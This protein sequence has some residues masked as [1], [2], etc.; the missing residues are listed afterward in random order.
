MA[1]SAWNTRPLSAGTPCSRLLGADRDYRPSNSGYIL[2]PFSRELNQLVYSQDSGAPISV[3]GMF[4]AQNFVNM[5]QGLAVENP[6]LRDEDKVR[7]DVDP[8]LQNRRL[9]GICEQ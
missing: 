6:A 7:Q 9:V 3:P 5:R 4:P 8:E 1:R 2:E